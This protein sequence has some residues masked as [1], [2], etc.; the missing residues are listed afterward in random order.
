MSASVKFKIVPGDGPTKEK[1]PG[2]LMFVA[3][4]YPKIPILLFEP[5]H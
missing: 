2:V 4:E 3:C 5:S 1:D